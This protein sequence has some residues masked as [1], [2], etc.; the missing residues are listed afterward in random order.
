ADGNSVSSG[1]RGEIVYTSL[2]NYAMPLI[3]YCVGDLAIS[4]DDECTC[5]RSFPMLKSIEGR[6]DSLL[7]LP[8]GRIMSPRAFTVSLLEFGLYD[9]I[10][11]FRIVQKELGLFKIYIQPEG[12]N[13]GSKI[14]SDKLK[15]HLQEDL[16]LKDS[17]VQI[18]VEFMDE[19]P[20]DKTGK[21]RAVLSEI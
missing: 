16:N 5:G 14:L 18:D 10:K 4:L 1:E 17:E 6:K 7:R 3:R 21:H 9:Q 8:D 19:M 12:E 13:I 15:T 2:F 11:Q 20:V